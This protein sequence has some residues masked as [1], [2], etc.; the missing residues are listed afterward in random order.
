MI[1]LLTLILAA[2]LATAEIVDKVAPKYLAEATAWKVDLFCEKEIK[3]VQAALFVLKSDKQIEGKNPGHVYAVFVRGLND[4]GDMGDRIVSGSF[5]TKEDAMAW[6]KTL[7]EK[8]KEAPELLP[9]EPIYVLHTCDHSEN[10]N[11]KGG[12]TEETIK[13]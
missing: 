4:K 12:C 13:P 6:F 10:G 1:E 5:A 11:G 3:D 8:A 7:Q 9:K 2:R